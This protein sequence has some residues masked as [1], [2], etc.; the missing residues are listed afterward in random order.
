VYL[1]IKTKNVLIAR[2]NSDNT[3]VNLELMNG[4]KYNRITNVMQNIKSPAWVKMPIILLL[5][6]N[7]NF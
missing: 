2:L 5:P 3:A 4:E 1:R 6:R 7:N